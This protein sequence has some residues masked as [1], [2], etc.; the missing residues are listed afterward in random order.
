MWLVF[1]LASALLAGLTS[2]LAKC[3]IRKTDS[4]V[5]TAVRTAV[6]VVFAWTMVGVAGSFGQIADI[7]A[8]SLLF[9]ILSGLATGAS[10]LCYF[11]ALQLGDVNKVVPV[12]KSSTVLTIVL[13]FV[14][15]GERVSLATAAA[16]ASIGLGTL[17]MVERRDVAGEPG[18]RRGGWLPF[19]V[20]SAVFASLTAL[21]GK[22]GIEGVES[23]L[24][25][26]VRC[27][28]V[29]AMAWLV[30]LARGKGGLVRAS[31]RGELGFL[32]LSGL[33]TGGSWLCYF[34]ALQKG[35][36]SVVV[37]VE[38]LSIL[39]SIGFAFVAF[40]ERLTR[41]GFT[42]LCLVT[43]GTLAMVAL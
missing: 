13:A 28:V 6:V 11:R 29:L 7:D 31:P 12:D 40:H 3:G 42:G 5:A 25:T 36:A 19:V 8:R 30:V 41:K 38:K 26:A 14:F 4:D 2:I 15:L 34:R 33:A 35:P 22:V 21:L 18:A 17:M 10:W 20:L 32:C 23:N 1:A 43:A 27:V 9:L 39:V 16:V 37:P 24:G